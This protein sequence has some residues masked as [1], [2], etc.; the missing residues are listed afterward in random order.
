MRVKTTVLLL[1]AVLLVGGALWYL[2]GRE[3]LDERRRRET[4]RLLRIHPGRIQ[5][6]V[7]DTGDLRVDCRIT[8]GFWRIVHPVKAL[9]DA[10]EMDRIL[11]G[12]SMME[13]SEII[14]PRERR[15]LGLT[16]RDFGL[17]RPRAR[18]EWEDE[19][20]HNVLLIGR[21]APVGGRVYVMKEGADDIISVAS[22]L[23]EIMPDSVLALRDRILFHGDPRRAYRLEIRRAGGFLQAIKADDG[24]WRLQQPI[25]ARADRGAVRQLI[26]RIFEW[27]IEDFVAD[28]ISDA[29]V[30]GLDDAATQVTVFT[31]GQ[32]A[33]QTVLL[34]S[35]RDQR[36]DSVY[37]RRRDGHSV[38][39]VS[40]ETLSQARVRPNDLRDRALLT[41]KPQRIASVHIEQGEHSL[42]MRRNT[43]HVWEIRQPKRWQADSDRMQTLLNAW[44]DTRIAVFVDDPTTNLAE[45]GFTEDALRITFGV[46]PIAFTVPQEDEP[47]TQSVSIRIAQT[48]PDREDSLLVKKE[49]EPSLYEIP[50]TAQKAT[51]W[52]PLY[53][54]HREVI[55]VQPASVRRIRQMRDGVEH[56]VER[57]NADR[58]SPVPDMEQTI[59]TEFIR[60]VLNTLS[61]LKVDEYVADDPADWSPYGLDEPRVVWSLDLTGEAG[62]RRVLMMGTQ[63]ADG[64]VY[65]RTRGHDVVFLLDQEQSALLMRRLHE[66]KP[67]STY[68][69][70]RDPETADD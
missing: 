37:A 25:V 13:K 55:R 50:G 42:V 29:T 30:Y 15:E 47:P 21:D 68:E 69:T 33:G 59:S 66:E 18:I 8:N 7:I 35:V 1:M 31:E 70:E 54:R 61:S 53:Y 4:A 38:F 23:L 64:R 65:G 5:R 9:A 16:L 20:T 27:R 2:E 6:V 12:L 24:S 28:A 48:P 56:V 45:L 36:P 22:E 40:A 62:I 49:G 19:T 52:N 41:V 57:D 51:S 60:S 58:F 10:G 44:T 26:D 46:E 63:R 34:G 3:E 32:E 43:N 11:T 67:S 17:E 39:S 14:S